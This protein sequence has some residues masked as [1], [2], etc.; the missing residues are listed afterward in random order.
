VFQT[1]KSIQKRINLLGNDYYLA[2]IYRT[3]HWRISPTHVTLLE[4][5]LDNQRI[6]KAK[7]DRRASRFWNRVFR[8]GTQVEGG[9][10]TEQ[11]TDEVLGE[12]EQWSQ[13][14]INIADNH[15]VGYAGDL[16]ETRVVRFEKAFNRVN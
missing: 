4:D 13:R 1:F 3:L 16:T 14:I 11:H 10:T 6:N 7:F 2:D 5:L 12:D 8:H 9:I 15:D